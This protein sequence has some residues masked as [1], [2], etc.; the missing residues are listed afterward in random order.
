MKDRINKFCNENMGTI[1][2]A[3]YTAVAGVTIAMGVVYVKGVND[4]TVEHIHE[5][6][7]AGLEKTT[8]VY[9]SGRTITSIKE[10]ITE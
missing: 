10:T 6:V 4:T 7:K 9:K 5:V 3:A 1:Q 2:A 8:I